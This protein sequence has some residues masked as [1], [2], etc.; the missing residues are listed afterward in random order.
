MKCDRLFYKEG[1][2]YQLSRDCSLLTA[3]K[4]IDIRLDYLSLAPDGLLT[5]KKGYAWDGC[6][7]PTLDDKTN[8]RG[9][10]FHDAIYQ[11]MR[12]G[13]ISTDWREYADKEVL[14]GL[15]MQDGM[16]RFRAWY[17]YEGVHNFVAKYS[18]S[19]EEQKEK[20]AP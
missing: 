16:N 7:G 17:Y 9:G 5:L 14:K 4:G 19:A 3:I 1:Y 8:M 6:S 20:S 15:C 11:L 18:K 2:K 12:L 10:A 13:L